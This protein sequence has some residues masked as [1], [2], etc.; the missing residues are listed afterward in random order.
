MTAVAER[1]YAMTRVSGGSYL[2]P[3]NDGQ[4]LWHIYSFMDG[5]SYGLNEPDRRWWACARFIGTYDQAVRAVEQNVENYG[6]IHR[7]TFRETDSYL[8]TRAEAIRRALA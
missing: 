5:R 6:Y 7:D 1:K 3:S 2:L 8:P 4:T